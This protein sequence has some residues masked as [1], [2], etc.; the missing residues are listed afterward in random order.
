MKFIW[1]YVMATG[2]RTRQQFFKNLL[3]NLFAWFPN[4]IWFPNSEYFPNRKWKTISATGEQKTVLKSIT[5]PFSSLFKATSCD[6]YFSDCASESE[7]L[8]FTIS[9]LNN[10]LLMVLEQKIV[11]PG[12]R[13]LYPRNLKM[14]SNV[15]FNLNFKVHFYYKWSL[16]NMFKNSILKFVLDLHFKV[17]FRPKNRLIFKN[18]PQIHKCQNWTRS[19]FIISKKSFSQN[20]S[21][22]LPVTY[23]FIRPSLTGRIMVWPPAGG[24]AG[25]RAASDILDHL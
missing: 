23:I 19:S 21:M 4:S 10:F 25:G 18:L 11:L 7:G 17:K 1:P 14:F 22:Q 5:G 8:Q 13:K 2:T 3:R 12:Y 16:K 15:T 20:C 6:L 24:W 9:M